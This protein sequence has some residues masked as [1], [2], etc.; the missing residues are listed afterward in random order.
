MALKNTWASG[1]IFRASDAN[2]LANAVN[3]HFARVFVNVS[4]AVTLG[5]AEKTD[6]VV[7]VEANGAPALPTAVANTN[8]YTIVNVSNTVRTLTCSVGGQTINT[9]ASISLVPNASVDVFAY[10]SNWRVV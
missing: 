7:Y 10:N 3:S 9:Q 1:D 6:Y 8:R 4:G 5:A 2:A